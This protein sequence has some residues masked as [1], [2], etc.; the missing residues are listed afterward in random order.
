MPNWCDNTISIT[1]P[2][3]EVKQLY[4][5][6]TAEEP[7]RGLCESLYPMPKELKHTVSPAPEDGKQ[8]IVDGHNN[9][10]DWACDKWGT[11]W[12][13]TDEQWEMAENTDGTATIEGSFCTA[14]G[15]PI[16]VYE[17]ARDIHPNLFIDAMYY[18]SG[19]A[20]A[21]TWASD[22]GEDHYSLEG[23]KRD[24]ERTLPEELNDAFAITENWEED[25]EELSEWLKDG[26]EAKKEAESA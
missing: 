19:C 18:E 25:P 17:H 21:G 16:G 22:T 14:W 10:Y 7:K 8:P 6:L 1:G 12:D 5:R 13:T 4:G 20:F 26:A 23:S 9:W 24:L 2:T 3:E 11:K 15:P